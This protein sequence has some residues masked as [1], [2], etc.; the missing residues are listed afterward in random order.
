VDDHSLAKVHEKLFDVLPWPVVFM[1][2]QR[3]ARKVTH[4]TRIPITA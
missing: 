3:S 4:S 1:Q 2:L